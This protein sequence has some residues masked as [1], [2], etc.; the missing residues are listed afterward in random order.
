MQ[1]QKIKTAECVNP[2]HP[3]K[4]CDRISD[5][6]LDECLKQDP[7]TRAAIETLGGHGVVTV[8]GELTTNAYVNVRDIV[9]NIVGTKYGVNVNIVKQSPEIAS[10]VDNGGAGDQGIMVGYACDENPAMI[11][12]ELFLARSL[13]EYIYNKHK[14]DGKTQI[15]IKDGE[16]SVIVAS[17][18]N[19]PQERLRNLVIDWAKTQIKAP[20][21]AHFSENTVELHI[22]PAGDWSVSGFEADT[23]LTGR[24]LAVDN[25]GP[26][27]PIGGGAFS[28]KDGT[29]VDRSG[30]YKA[31]QKAVQLLKE[32]NAHEV[33][34]YLAYAIGYPYPVHASAIIDGGEEID[35][36]IDKQEFTPTQI[37]KDLGLDQPIFEQTAQ[38]GHFGH[39]FPWDK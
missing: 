24:K 4:M 8:V 12:Q 21:L 9:E 7:Q 15:T 29:K 34:V 27:I 31:R 10:G 20:E 33:I 3:D 36:A 16:V 11:P 32:K 39:G 35:L 14:E 6:I 5:A 2:M 37:I 26:R 30:A 18:A 1:K 19:V 17:W 23:G 38:W 13:N 25:Y 28:G 22:N